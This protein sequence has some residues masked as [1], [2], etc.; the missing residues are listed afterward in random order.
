MDKANNEDNIKSHNKEHNYNNIMIKNKYNIE[1]L[2]TTHN[3]IKEIII[4]YSK[5]LSMPMD[6]WLDD[7]LIAAKIY[8]I[9]TN[10][11]I[12]GF[13]AIT[14]NM[15]NNFYLEKEYIH[16]GKELIE[17]IIIEFNIKKVF[18]STS[19]SQ[20]STYILGYKY[21]MEKMACWFTDSGREVD[22][23]HMFEKVFIRNIDVNEVEKVI[24]ISG[25]F[26]LEESGGF[27]TI[28]ERIISETMFFLEKDNEIYGIGIIEKSQF[29]DNI[30]SIGMFVNKEHRKKGVAKTILVQLRKWANENGYITVAGCWYYNTLSRLSLQSAGMNLTAMGYEAIIEEKEVLKLRT[31]NP[32]GEEVLD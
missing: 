14:S 31:G 25:D 3:D 4:N 8:K 7:Q 9:V 27:L 19:D 10:N 21:N 28:E 15:L 29:V 1:I 26:F 16:L 12:I 18:I 22:I 5:T 13:V 24:E 6:S 17:Y 30:V 2:A 20:I 32:P 23:P 11:K